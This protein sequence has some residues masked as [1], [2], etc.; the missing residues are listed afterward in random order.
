MIRCVTGGRYCGACEPCEVIDK[1]NV[2][3]TRLY[4]IAE[5]VSGT[6]TE[7]QILAVLKR[8]EALEPK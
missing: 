1:L 4:R 8:L 3:I 6:G 7:K 5:G 2:Q